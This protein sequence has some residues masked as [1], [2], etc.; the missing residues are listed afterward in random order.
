MSKKV[1]SQERYEVTRL[2][3]EGSERYDV[4]TNLEGGANLRSVDKVPVVTGRKAS[5]GLSTYT[6]LILY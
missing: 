6:I 4:G 5:V 3:E 1:R 2:K